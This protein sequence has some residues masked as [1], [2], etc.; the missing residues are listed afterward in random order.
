MARRQTLKLTALAVNKANKAGL[1]GDGAG[2]W[3]SVG[4]TG[5]KSWVFR[6]MLYGKAREMGLGALHTISLA[7]AR[8]KALQCRKLLLDGKDPLEEK[9]ATQQQRRL[10]AA[11]T[12]SFSDCAEA[13]IAAHRSGWK[14]TKHIAQWK[15]TLET[16]VYPKVEGLSVAAIDTGIVLQCLE[17]IWNEKP[18]TASRLRG[19]IE[20]VL[21]W[22][23]VRGYRKGENPARWR[24]HL[25]KLLPARSKV[26]KIEHHSALPYKQLPEFIKSLREQK[27]IAAQALE[28]AILTATRTGEIIGARWAEINLQEAVWIIPAARMKAG[29]EHRVPLSA[30]AI[31]ILQEMEKI[32]QGDFVFAGA[33]Y[34]KPLSN[35]ALLMTLRRMNRADLTAHGFRSTFRD[36]VSE[37]TATPREVAEM[38]LAHSIGDAVEAAYRRGDLFE[39]R[40]E[41]ME[42]WAGFCVGCNKGNNYE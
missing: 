2:L 34:G 6:F 16:Y 40:R 19:R 13:Y 28:F 31:E 15:S 39:K 9:Q 21:D 36:W 11:K 5:S 37:T 33:R 1:Y 35:M 42:D 22:A 30:R 32:K 24:G 27:G 14:N 26:A 25:D 20:A 23:K 17:P 18:E 8:E 41:L 4:K 12:T 38:A 10:D 29:R 7:E 3:L